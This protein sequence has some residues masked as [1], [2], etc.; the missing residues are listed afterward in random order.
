VLGLLDSFLIAGARL[1]SRGR[2]VRV[3]IEARA[4]VCSCYCCFSQRQ[5][6]DGKGGVYMSAGPLHAGE[7]IL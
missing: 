2:M 4:F 5:G 3:E 1:S 6:L 7:S